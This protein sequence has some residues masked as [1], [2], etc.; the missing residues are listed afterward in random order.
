M[1]DIGSKVR[2]PLP[3]NRGKGQHEGDDNPNPRRVDSEHP[4]RQGKD[5]RMAPGSA[6]SGAGAH[7]GETRGPEFAVQIDLHAGGHLEA[8]HIYEQ[9]KQCDQRDR[10]KRR[11][12][13][14]DDGPV[15]VPQI[16]RSERG[17]EAALRHSRQQEPLRPGVLHRDVEKGQTCVVE[18][19]HEHEAAHHHREVASSLHDEDEA[20]G[21]P[22]APFPDHGGLENPRKRLPVKRATPLITESAA[23]DNT[24]PVPAKNPPRPD[25]G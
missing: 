3:K 19:A 2:I 1:I 18:R 16:A 12:L 20:V 25:T 4:A 7:S 5:E 22:R 8:V 13:A 14:G 17:P 9:A 21:R 10:E 15:H 11:H 6:P 23:S 24:H